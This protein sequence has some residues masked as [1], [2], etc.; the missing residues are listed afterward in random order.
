M[1]I[2]ELFKKVYSAKPDKDAANIKNYC[3]DLHNIT[4]C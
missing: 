1:R 4:F 3:I 2:A